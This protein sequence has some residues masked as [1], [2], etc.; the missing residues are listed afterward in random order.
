MFTSN[1]HIPVGPLAAAQ[2]QAAHFRAAAMLATR[3]LSR[4]LERDHLAAAPEDLLVAEVAR[5]GMVVFSPT[6]RKH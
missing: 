5:R 6:D 4:E 2:R 3:E 1:P